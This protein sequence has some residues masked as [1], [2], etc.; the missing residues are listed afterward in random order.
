MSRPRSNS[1][2]KGSF[3]K[4]NS[5]TILTVI[6]VCTGSA[7]G[8]LLKHNT[9]GEWSKRDIMYIAFPGECFLRYDKLMNCIIIKVCPRA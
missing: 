5:L 3:L 9:T 1:Q 2:S 6:G 7:V 4:E 8:L